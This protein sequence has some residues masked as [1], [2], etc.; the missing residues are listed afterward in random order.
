MEGALQ[1]LIKVS[2]DF[3]NM[4][5]LHRWLTPK[6][7]PSRPSMRFARRQNILED[8]RHTLHFAFKVC[9]SVLPRTAYIQNLN[10]VK[11]PPDNTLE[12]IIVG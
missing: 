1:S 7:P 12:A 4:V 2:P 3:K 9:S 6:A 5:G 11:T 8:G 10:L